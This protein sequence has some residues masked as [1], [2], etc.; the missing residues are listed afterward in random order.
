VNNGVLSFT[1]HKGDKP[2]GEG[3]PAAYKDLTS[4]SQVR[5]SARSSER[6]NFPVRF[7]QS[8]GQRRK[9][10]LGQDSFGAPDPSACQQGF[11]PKSARSH[12]R[13]CKLGSFQ[14]TGQQFKLFYRSHPRSE[15]GSV[16]PKERRTV[17]PTERASLGKANILPFLG[18]TAGV[19]KTFQL[20][21]RFIAFAPMTPG[22]A[23]TPGPERSSPL[24]RTML[25]FPLREITPQV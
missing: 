21:G 24:F 3:E 18:H 16:C 12:E 9:G 13:S 11:S 1:Q 23:P 14:R 15:Q 8:Q 5:S 4:R 19:K 17:T 25:S 10:P 6:D 22:V 20:V 2:T 7:P